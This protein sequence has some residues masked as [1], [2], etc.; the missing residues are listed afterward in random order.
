M[1]LV[2]LAFHLIKQK[3]KVTLYILHVNITI[4]IKVSKSYNNFIL[5]AVFYVT[6]L[7]YDNVFLIETIHAHICSI[8]LRITFNYANDYIEL[9]ALYFDF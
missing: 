9:N 3:P 2:D 8:A 5:E 1:I 4:K 6:A 7:T